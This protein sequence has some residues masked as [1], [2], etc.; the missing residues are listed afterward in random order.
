MES[1]K[2][3]NENALVR[4]IN[5]NKRSER[6]IYFD[7][8]NILACVCVIFLHMNGIVHQY[9]QMRAWKTA[10][11]F[12]V[13]CYWAVPVF[14]MLSGATLL[15]Y[16]EK[17][18]TKT[19]FKKRFIK[20]LI[21]WIVW[22]LISYIIKNQNMNLFQF[23]K[24][25]MYCKI[26]Y[27]YW[28]IPLTL[29]LYCIIPI[30][31]VF[32]EKE[33]YRKIL[34][35]IVLFIFIFR[36]IIYPICVIFDKPFP[37]VLD[38]FLN[39]NGY[40]MF[41]ILG[42]LLSTTQLPKRSRIIIYILGIASAIFRYIYTY[43]FSTRESALNGDLFDYCSAVSVLLAM[44]VFVFIKNINWKKIID[45]LHIKAGTLSKLSNC[46]FGVYLIHILIMTQLTDKLKLNIY[47][48]EYR[49][50]G[51][52]LLY[53]ICVGIVCIIKKIPILKKIVP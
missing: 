36:A 34:K 19:F 16:K 31:T 51:A 27:V 13:A 46:S 40:I 10:L 50:L 1:S 45:K 32:T 30:L 53:I 14:I 20:I 3:Q 25:F 2:V 21:P 28:F 37:A 44:A 8:L 48:I 11:I 47:S 6:I 23:V 26:E 7:I 39:N 35:A 12:E 33:E 41:L 22:S 49:T 5:N 17:Y 43:Y 52:I 38:Y 9:T 4:C 29:Y 42:Y 24:D 18:D 15:K